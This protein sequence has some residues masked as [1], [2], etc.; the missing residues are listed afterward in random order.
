MGKR[1]PC[2]DGII[3]IDDLDSPYSEDIGVRPYKKCPRRKGIRKQ[4][5]EEVS[6]EKLDTLA[7]DNHFKNLWSNF[8]EDKRMLFTYFDCLWF[9][10]YMTASS[11]EN[12]LTWIKDKDIFSKKYVLVPIVYWSHWSL[13]ILCNF[14]SQSENGSPCMLLLDS[15]QMAGP[16]RLEP[17]IRKFVLDIFRSEGRPEYE[18]SISQIPLLVPKV[19]QQR[20]GEECGNYVL[21]FIDLFVHQA[22]LDFSVKE[23]P[24]FMTDDWFNLEGFTH[25]SNNQ[26]DPVEEMETQIA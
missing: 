4:K 14:D 1:K 17:A 3:T 23:Y 22:P 10:V 8:P 7:F 13:L 20:N 26:E 25:F 24:Y 21:Y 16:R 11:K 6:N 5:A 18:Q 9:S 2:W 19:P 12:M 15:L